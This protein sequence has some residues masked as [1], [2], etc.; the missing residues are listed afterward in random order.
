ML[1]D[2]VGENP[3]KP[4]TA[5]P[6]AC[7]PPSLEVDGEVHAGPPAPLHLQDVDSARFRRLASLRI[8]ER[9][10]ASAAT[11]LPASLQHEKCASVRFH[12]CAKWDLKTA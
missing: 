10:L 6:L 1:V 5:S 3:T 11:P 4:D 2:D 12:D 7:A 9:H 8:V